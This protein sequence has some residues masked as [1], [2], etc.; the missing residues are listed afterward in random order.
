MD[1]NFSY[2]LSSFYF[3]IY[4]S[5]KL[6]KERKKGE[7]LSFLISFVAS[8]LKKLSHISNLDKIYFNIL[9]SFFYAF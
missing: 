7:L 4:L 3:S 6:S 2:L 5:F 9:V 8:N 1:A